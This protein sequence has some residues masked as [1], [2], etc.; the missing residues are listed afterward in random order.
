L[1][2]GRSG[3]CTSIKV[4][5][6]WNRSAVPTRIARMALSRIE[7]LDLAALKGQRH[8][9]LVC[10]Y[11]LSQQLTFHPNNVIS[12]EGAPCGGNEH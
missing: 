5:E 8:S 12:R 7:R 11:I 3:G 2:A 9:N 4:S 10:S 6:D 1:D